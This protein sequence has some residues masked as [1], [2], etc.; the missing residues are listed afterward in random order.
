MK[1]LTTVSVW[2]SAS[3]GFPEKALLCDGD[4]RSFQPAMHL[5]ACASVPA[6]C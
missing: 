5:D 2:S 6:G 4:L 1:L 3:A